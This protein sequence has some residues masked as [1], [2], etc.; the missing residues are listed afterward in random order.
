MARRVRNLFFPL[1]GLLLVVEACA[2]CTGSAPAQRAGYV[3]IREARPAAAHAAHFV[4][5]R[6]INWQIPPG[7]GNGIAGYAS[8]VGVLAGQPVSL[9]VSTP[10]SRYRVSAFRMGWYSGR[11]G[12]LEWRSSWLPGRKQHP[13]RLT[14]PTT[15]TYAADWTSPA[16]VSTRQ[17]PPGDYLLRLDSS[18]GGMNYVPLAVRTAS[19]AG[20]VVLIS[21]VTTWQA[22]NMWGCCDLYAGS[23]GSFDSRS[24]AVSFDRPYADEFGAGQFLRG[25]LGVLALSE[26]L[27][28]RLD[29]L[30][31]VDLQRDPRI[32]NGAAAVISM[33][34]DEYWSP[35]M[36]SSLQTA[37]DSGTNAAF[38]G[39]N[40]IFRRIR[41][42]ATPSGPDRLE[43][44]Y[45]RAAED[46][47]ATSKPQQATADWPSPPAADPESRLIGP[48]YACNLGVG[49]QADGIVTTT[50]SWI[51]AGTNVYPGERLSGLIGPETDAVQPGYPTPRPLQVLM[52]SPT[53]CPGGGPDYADTTYR[54]TPSGAAVFDAG[55]IAWGCTLVDA[56]A[57]PISATTQ[58]VVR[59][60]TGNILRT[61]AAG[62]AGLLHPARDN[63]R[64]FQIAG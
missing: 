22:Y 54:T 59:Q 49:H 13:A 44:N 36:R 47:L 3:H 42:A 4:P 45:K 9:F 26:R 29:Y 24:R 58:R 63:L 1:L 52:H 53:S 56:C 38:F 60:M 46:P 19:A 21:P 39:A 6:W 31:S 16:R 32:L 50:S 43:I 11:Y 25:Q 27:H 10:A 7:R 12:R 15:N 2:G 62:P 5:R 18:A 61:F 40:A 55:T 35:Q 23:D 51:Y 41:F 30:T 17:W 28:L 34:H 37:I 57:A 48:Q 20:R 14:G 33:N 8:P 64:S